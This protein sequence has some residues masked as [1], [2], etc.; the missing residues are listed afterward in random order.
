MASQMIHNAKSFLHHIELRAGKGVPW[1][2]YREHSDPI[3]HVRIE[4]FPVAGDA[5][6]MFDLTGGL[7]PVEEKVIREWFEPLLQ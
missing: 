6:R 5:S 3:G 7:T 1:L 4:A 2:C